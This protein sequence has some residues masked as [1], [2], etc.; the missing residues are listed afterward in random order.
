VVIPVGGAGLIA[1]MALA[2]K[3]LR[4]NAQ[5]IG[6]EPEYCPSYTEALKLGRPTQVVV[7]PTLGDGLAVPMVGP[8]SFEVAKHYVDKVVT[9]SE[10]YLALAVLRCLEH[11]KAVVEGG[12]AAGLAALLPGGPLDIPELKGKK[13]V[14]PLCG[15]NIDVNM[16]GRVI[17]RGLAADRR[18]I[19]F[20]ATVSDRPGGLKRLV[21]VISDNDASIMD[22]SHE[23][24]W[25]HTS[26]SQVCVLFLASIMSV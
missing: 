1:G 3:T 25:L 8:H 6:V 4:P 5:V 2:I 13:V 24:A 23:R 18:L 14:V 10:K 17:E 16:L 22:I 21:T 19:R 15:G 7:S 20:S 26:V 12:G 11:E 9:V